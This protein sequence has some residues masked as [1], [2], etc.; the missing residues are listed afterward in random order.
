MKI[1]YIANVRMPTEKAHGHQIMKM[2]ELFASNGAEVQLVLPNRVN[3]LSQ[4][5]VFDYY[6][7]KNNFV[8]KKLKIFDPVFLMRAPAGWYIKLQSLFFIISLFFYLLFKKNRQKII[9][10]TRDEYLLPVLSIFSKNIVWEG[11]ALPANKK[12]YV[13]YFNCIRALVVLTGEMKK[14]LEQDGV[15]LSKI[16]V[17]PDAVDLDIFGIEISPEMARQELGLPVDAIILGYTGSFKT[18]GMDKG[19]NDIIKV[20]NLLKK[21]WPKILFVAVGGNQTDIDYYQQRAVDAGVEKQT[22]FLGKVSQDKLAIYQQA[23]NILLMPFPWTEHYAY[24]MSPLKMFEYLAAKRPIVA[25]DL[26]TI[27]EILDEKSAVFCRPDDPAD[28]AEKIK[29]ILT[30][31]N[32]ATA[33]SQGAYQKS[34]QYTWHNRVRSIIGFIK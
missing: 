1:L 4:L 10:Y 3:Q 26:P 20:I 16:I 9:F 8:I 12:R 15:S 24:F 6:Q 11:H 7:V 25:S 2:C 23:F 34:K 14:R 27:R 22:L 30:D 33:I 5:D 32:L 31:S 18:K 21:N 29:L 28:L 19:I 13:K 17:S